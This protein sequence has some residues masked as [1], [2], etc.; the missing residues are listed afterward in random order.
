MVSASHSH[1][2]AGDRPWCWQSTD[3]GS[4]MAEHIWEHNVAENP[5]RI[6]YQ[7]YHVLHHITP[8]SMLCQVLGLI[9]EA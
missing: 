8:S 4:N 9:P 3:E 7:S 6:V 5:I 2:S 1:Q